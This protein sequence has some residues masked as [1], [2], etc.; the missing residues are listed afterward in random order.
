MSLQMT[1]LRG[2]LISCTYNPSYPETDSLVYFADG[3]IILSGNK[4]VEFGPTKTLKHKIADIKLVKLSHE[5]R[6]IKSSI[7]TIA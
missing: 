1:A 6:I 3:L 7:C 5:C 4:I 2:P